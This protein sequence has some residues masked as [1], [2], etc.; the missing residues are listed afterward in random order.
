MGMLFAQKVVVITGAGSGIGRGIA[1]GFC[2]DGADV[3]GFGRTRSALEETARQ[4]G[5]GRMHVVVGDVAKQEDVD[6]L[7]AETHERYGRVDVLV[8]NAAVYPKVTFLD[9]PV[10]EWAR[11]MEMNVVGVAR[12]CHLALPGMLER[13]HGRII[14]VG[15]L[16]WKAPIPASSAYSASK[17]AMRAL[18][19]AIA[20]EID[21][22]RY[23]D[24][25]INE[26]LPGIFK[27][28]MSEQG[29]DPMSVYAH[30]RTL[31]SLPSGGPTGQTFMQ[32]EIYV[33]D[34]GIRA[35]AKRML[36]RLGGR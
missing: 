35:R 2:G 1:S 8:N 13:G 12:C 27:T 26:L 19:L 29:D 24:V 23:P 21:R 9:T 18:T 20:S 5:R 22:A 36:S 7:F 31:A 14:N 30:A 17:A 6:R 11:V 4:H 15:S 3:V 28:S 34:Q 10:S 25:L 33:P 32:S 16:A